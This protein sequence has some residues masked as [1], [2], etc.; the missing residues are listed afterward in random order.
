MPQN[1]D[2]K[3]SYL[4]VNSNLIGLRNRVVKAGSRG[5]Y[6]LRSS[7]GTDDR[8]RGVLGSY[9]VN[10]PMGGSRQGQRNLANF[11]ADKITHGWHL[12]Q[13]KNIPLS[14]VP[15]S[16]IDDHLGPKSGKY[17]IKLDKDAWNA[18]SWRPATRD[19]LRKRIEISGEEEGDP[20]WGFFI[21]Q[22]FPGGSLGA[23]SGILPPATINTNNLYVDHTMFYR[24][25]SSDSK[26]RQASEMNLK[27]ESIYN[28]YADTTPEYEVISLEASEPMLTNFYCLESESRNT[29]S[30]LNSPDYFGQ[31]TLDGQLQELNID[32]DPEPDPWFQ[33]VEGPAGGFTESDTVQ[34]YTLYSKGLQIIKNTT[35]LEGLK[36]VFNRKYKNIVILNSDLDTMSNLVTRDDQTSGLRNLPFYNKITIGRDEDSVSDPDGI[37]KGR[38]FFGRL[39]LDLNRELG[40]GAGDSLIDVMQLYIVQNIET[41]AQAAPSANFTKRTLTRLSD[42]N[43]GS[44]VLGVGSTVVTFNFNMDKFLEDCNSV[45]M[46]AL[47]DRINENETTDDNFILIRNYNQGAQPA[48]IESVKAF[49][50]LNEDDRIN[51]PIRSTDQIILENKRCYNETLLYRIDKRVVDAAGNASAA[52]VQTFYIGKSFKGRN[53]YYIDSQ[54]KYGVRYRYDISEIRVVF[55][56]KYSYKDLKVFFEMAAGYGRAV[57]N[58]LGFYR[59]IRSDIRLDDYVNDQVMEYASADKDL[60]FSAVG[61]EGTTET[62]SSQ[63]GYYIFKPTNPAGIVLNDFLDVRR[64]GTTF[65]GAEDSGPTADLLD[66]IEVVIKEGFGFTG[67]DS[68]GAVPGS[69]VGLE[70]RQPQILTTPSAASQTPVPGTSPGTRAQQRLQQQLTAQSGPQNLMNLLLGRGK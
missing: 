30:T 39:I 2:Y 26:I 49:Q 13:V 65:V 10:Y 43:P 20:Y 38:S 44:N 14:L 67:N 54:V 21:K 46:G 55:G 18:L 16:T 53:V 41:P 25:P 9:Y 61:I 66:K 1:P 48:T 4:L 31:I 58:A 62:E 42:T 22:G 56:S 28:Y 24:T 19:L 37:I 17:L 27:V 52:P 32:G 45:R 12:Q 68:G 34:L 47:F 36:A 11:A 60:P 15:I 59:P 51:Y 8:L 40:Q 6:A 3:D 64:T 69:L 70:P 50:T 63:V 5:N 35:G 57:G 7:W 29:G 33:T 23:N